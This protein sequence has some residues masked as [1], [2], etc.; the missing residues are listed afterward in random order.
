MAPDNCNR[1]DKT[2]FTE[3]GLEGTHTFATFA[4]VIKR[5]SPGASLAR[6]NQHITARISMTD[7]QSK[8]IYTLTDEA[9]LLATCSLLP[10][11]RTFTAFEANKE[12]CRLFAHFSLPVS[13][14]VF[15]LRLINCLTAL[16]CASSV[17]EKVWP[18]CPLATKNIASPAAG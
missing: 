11:I 3:E 13:T 14:D 6:S 1:R 8:I 12:A 17:L 7:R 16:L 4:G 2:I 15:L 18:P 10:I 9:P 5:V